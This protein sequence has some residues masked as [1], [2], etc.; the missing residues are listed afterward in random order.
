MLKRNGSA[1]DAAIAALFC[2][3]VSV[4]QSMGL[5]GGFALTMYNRSTKAV[6]TLIAREM[7]PKAAYRDMFIN[8]TRIT[9]VK[10]IAV[11]GEL[12]GYWELHQRYGK[13]PWRT[14]VE[15]TI[16][17]CREGHI[18]GPYLGRI[19]K[20]FENELRDSASLAEIYINPET[21]NVWAE[22]EKIKRP[23]LAKTLE[24][25]AEEGADALYTRDGTLTHM[26]VEELQQLGGIITKGDFAA[27]KVAWGRP[28]SASLQNNVTLYSTPLPSSGGILA[29]IL[30]IMNNYDSFE[31]SPKLY[32]RL[33]ESFKFA[34]AQRSQFG[35][36]TFEPEVQRPFEEMLDPRYAKEIRQ[37]IKDEVTFNEFQYYGASFA[38][39]EDGG[40][41]HI[42]ILTETGDAI[43]VTSTINTM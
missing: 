36:P 33:V 4:S 39:V 41:A 5:G 34:Y 29:F 3:G 2:E 11:P 18:V 40:T 30:N 43:A 31:K 23:Q 22:G 32:Q 35:D 8:E 42:S 6:E 38:N 26:L 13:L 16:K 19:L 1:A 25:I 17:L 7:A 28:V 14:L 15:P 37:K 20:K 10:A 12:K 27:Y 21:G 9:G 24:I